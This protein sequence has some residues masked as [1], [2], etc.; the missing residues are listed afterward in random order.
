M[1]TI[2]QSFRV[3]IPVA[4]AVRFTQENVLDNQRARYDQV[5]FSQAKNATTNQRKFFEKFEKT[6]PIRVQYYTNYPMHKLD[7]VDCDDVVIDTYSPAMIKQYQ[8][9]KYRS[10]CK[11]ASI[12]GKL[13]IYFVQGVEYSDPDFLVP[14]DSYSLLG[15]LPSINAEIGDELRYNI[16]DMGFE[17]TVISGIVWNVALQAE[18]Y[19]T[20]VDITLGTPVDGVVEVT[21]DE[22]NNDLFGQLVDIS[23]LDD[24]N[25]F[26]RLHFGIQAYSR[27]YLTEPLD[28]ADE[29]PKSLLLEYRHD[30]EF[31]SDDIWGY[32]YSSDW[33]N[34]IR[35]DAD[36][37]LLK[38]AG[39]IDNYND[40]FG[41][42]KKLRAVPFR[43]VTFSILNIPSWAADKLNVVFAHDTKIINGEQWENDDFGTHERPNAKIDVGTYSIDLR[44]V[45]DRL[46]KND[47]EIVSL[48]AEF[49]PD[50]LEDVP[51]EG[52]TF[53]VDFTSNTP[54]VFSFEDIPS[55][56]HP[57]VTEFSDG[58][59]I[60]IVIDENESFIGRSFQL[61]ARC[62][63]YEG[64]IATIDVSQLFD[65]DAIE[66]ID[67]DIDDVD[68]NGNDGEEQVINVSSS[69]DYDITVTGF[70]FTVV[71]QSGYS[72]IK[73]T[74]PSENDGLASRTATVRLALMSN[75]LVFK[76]I[77]VTQIPLM[78]VS[79]PSIYMT[80]STAKAI[81][82]TVTVSTGTMYQMSSITS[83]ITIDA[84]I[85]T[86]TQTFDIFISQNLLSSPR[87]GSVTF[88]DLVNPSNDQTL[89]IQQSGA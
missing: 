5:R 10:D 62:P 25:Y 53:N 18:G 12:D 3:Q 16:Q 41:V 77:S 56:I 52:D 28:I 75:P 37:Y 63:D 47:E 88:T 66:Y 35:I 76:D 1:G 64:L 15:R 59:T 82:V 80:N 24:G 57:D 73:I 61:I 65:E 44:F 7:L 83:W 40:D 72:Q 54:G 2:N 33:V 22:K 8:N 67:T 79:P 78:V 60:E 9:L 86:G 48:D 89:V 51:F 38:P 70:A 45:E 34:A 14:G 4:N 68:F 30:G 13:F 21:Y 11:F 19:L 58:D 36:L 81:S 84:I 46:N 23:G 87:V 31:D 26:L 20:D 43:Q 17:S 74:T 85:R 55:W 6:D 50:T 49:D 39:E 71:K 32:L 42:S 27:T 29:H 69:G